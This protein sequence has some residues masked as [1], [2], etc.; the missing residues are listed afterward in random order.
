MSRVVELVAQLDVELS[1]AE[2]R[3]E[4]VASLLERLGLA[5]SQPEGCEQFSDVV[6]E[7]VPA[8]VA[9][10]RLSPGCH[11]AACILLTAAAQHGAS[12]RDVFTALAAAL[13]ETLK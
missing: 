6:L 1:Q 7:V 12:S 10:S 11:E 3:P 8:I 13:S 2:K 5:M 9:A 4:N